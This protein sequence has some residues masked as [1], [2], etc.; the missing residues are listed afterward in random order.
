MKRVQENFSI[1]EVEPSP[2]ITELSPAEPEDQSSSKG[3]SKVLDSDLVFQSG[4]IVWAWW[5][6]LGICTTDWALL[7]HGQWLL[8]KRSNGNRQRAPV[9]HLNR[10]IKGNRL[11]LRGSII[12]WPQKC[13]GHLFIFPLSQFYQQWMQWLSL[14][15]KL[16]QLHH[17]VGPPCKTFNGLYWEDPREINKKDHN[18]VI[19]RVHHHWLLI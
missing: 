11:V 12:V 9:D 16:W 13:F 1:D 5:P 2:I 10:K 4:T 18:M 15:T 19:L 6:N 14:M 8:L 17:R 3:G 7:T